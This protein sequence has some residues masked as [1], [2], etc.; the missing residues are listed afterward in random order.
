MRN[1]LETQ[2]FRSVSVCKKIVLLFVPCFQFMIHNPLFTDSIIV[3]T[4]LTKN[5]KVFLLQEK[6]LKA[7]VCGLWCNLIKLFFSFKWQTL[8]IYVN[9]CNYLKSENILFAL[10]YT[11]VCVSGTGPNF[12]LY[13]ICWIIGAYACSKCSKDKI[14]LGDNFIFSVIFCVKPQILDW[15]T[16]ITYCFDRFNKKIQLIPQFIPRRQFYPLSTLNQH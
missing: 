2:N 14:V 4:R 16:Y 7:M 3:L 13:L 6:Q 11:I 5:R 10:K 8:F 1:Y 9:L 12:T 15:F